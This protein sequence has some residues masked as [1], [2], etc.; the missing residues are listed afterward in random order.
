MHS[1]GGEAGD[2]AG[3]LRSQLPGARN[4]LWFDNG[5]GVFKLRRITLVGVERFATDNQGCSGFLD[6]LTAVAEL[7]K[8]FIFGAKYPHLFAALRNAR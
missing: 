6:S 3:P 5:S 1:N 4:G 8:L 7:T 2:S